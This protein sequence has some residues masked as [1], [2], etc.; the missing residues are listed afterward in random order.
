MN[1]KPYYRKERKRTIIR[2]RV[3]KKK[4]KFNE[5]NWLRASVS[6][7]GLIYFV[8]KVPN[9]RLFEKFDHKKCPLHVFYSIYNINVC[10]FNIEYVVFTF[11][12]L[13]KTIKSVKINVKYWMDLLCDF[14]PNHV[15]WNLLQWLFF[16]ESNPSNYSFIEF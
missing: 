6:E 4:E 5:W 8:L 2:L 15:E 7:K 13:T 9:A 14:I 1:V 3:W 11:F 16:L 12:V 10:N